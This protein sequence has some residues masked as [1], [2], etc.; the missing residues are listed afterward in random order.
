[1]IWYEELE[2]TQDLAKV[3]AKKNVSNGTIVI[4]ESQTKGRGT[5]GRTWHTCEKGKNVAFTL[6][7]Y[8]NCLIQKLDTLTLDKQ[9][10]GTE[11]ND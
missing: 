4:A 10:V 1:M 11:K 6:I 5:N 3:L 2:S 7:L 8:P 9:S